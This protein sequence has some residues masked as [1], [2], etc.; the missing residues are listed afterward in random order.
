MDG[1]FI[2]FVLIV[3]G[4]FFAYSLMQSKQADTAWGE[5]AR[6]LGLMMQTG[7][8]LSKRGMQGRV[9]G[10]FVSVST[11]TRGSGKSSRTNTRY[12]V[13]FPES[14]KLGLSIKRQGFLGSLATAFGAQDIHVDDPSFDNLVVIKG[15]D[16]G[17][18][19]AFLNED[20][21]LLMGRLVSQ[22]ETMEFYYDGLGMEI[23]GTESTAPLI[24]RRV[25][26]LVEGACSISSKKGDGKP[27]EKSQSGIPVVSVPEATEEAKE[28]GPG[29]DAVSTPPPLPDAGKEEVVI[30]PSSKMIEE[31]VE[32]PKL[33]GVGIDEVGQDL[34]GEGKSSSDIRLRFADR[35]EGKAV[36]GRGL[37]R[38]WRMTNF[39]F[40]FGKGA[41]CLATIEVKPA[42]GRSFEVVVCLPQS[43]PE[44]AAGEEFLFEGRLVKVE[45]LV[46]RFFV[47]GRDR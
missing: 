42:K 20:R 43:S 36:H 23:R 46:R 37:V 35:F 12:E 28:A 3:G 17:A 33:S 34:F 10:C 45:T 15:H 13:R 24:I 8:I 30:P 2:V 14:L 18:V 38:Q 25:R 16:A 11:V 44:I 26:Q 21:R 5:A 40:V 47:D 27:A 7:G 4:I 22:Y 39:D 29:S 9:A 32:P 19:R 31:K 41:L 6:N 1:G